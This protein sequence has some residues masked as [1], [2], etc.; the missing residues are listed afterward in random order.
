MPTYF[1]EKNE[2]EASYPL[3]GSLYKHYK[4][5]IYEVLTLATHTETNE[6]MV[7]YQSMLFGSIYARPLSEWNKPL[8]NGDVRFCELIDEKS[9]SLLTENYED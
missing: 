2:G 7:V 4:G 6:P 1:I 9:I 3:P 8:D 5:G